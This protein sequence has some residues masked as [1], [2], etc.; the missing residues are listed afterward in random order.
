MA[1]N[2]A[3]WPSNRGLVSKIRP[4]DGCKG[5][6]VP[7]TVVRGYDLRKPGGHLEVIWVMSVKGT[8]FHPD[9]SRMGTVENQQPDG[10]RRSSVKPLPALPSV[11]RR[12]GIADMAGCRRCPIVSLAPYRNGRL[13]LR[14]V[15]DRINFAAPDD[16]LRGG[17]VS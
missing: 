14:R 16:R 11:C 10:Y 7:S 6:T 3:K 9:G 8:A 4:S 2:L 17:D 5:N 1:A 15:Q 12:S 13:E